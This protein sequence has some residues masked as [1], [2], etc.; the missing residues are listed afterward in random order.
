MSKLFTVDE[1]ERYLR[2]EVMRA[3]G[4]KKWCRKH[5][6]NMDH[7]I[8]MIENGSAASLDRVLDAL[9]FRKVIRYEPVNQ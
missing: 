8:H 7:A 4:A 1:I 9:E 6:I 3:G 5:K 2:E